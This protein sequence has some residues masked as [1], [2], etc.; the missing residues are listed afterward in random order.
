M[1]DIREKELARLGTFVDRGFTQVNA[2]RD[3]RLAVALLIIGSVMDSVPSGITE[4]CHLVDASSEVH[5]GVAEITRGKLSKL[6]S[7]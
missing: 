2:T 3:E 6:Q 1:N 5:K 7:R 4:F